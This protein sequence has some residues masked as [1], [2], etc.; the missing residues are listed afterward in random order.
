MKLKDYIDDIGASEFARLIGVSPAQVSKYQNY[1]EIPKPKIARRI[2]KL[3][4]SLVD[5]SDIYEPYF[6]H[7]EKSN[8]SAMR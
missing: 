6:E 8:P 4:H 2:R 3:T 7:Q 5:Y 1:Q